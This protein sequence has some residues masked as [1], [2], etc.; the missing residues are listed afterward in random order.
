M[1]SL[2]NQRVQQMGLS[3]NQPDINMLEKKYVNINSKDRNVFMYPNSA[4]FEIDL[5]QSYSNIVSIKLDSC[6]LPSNTDLFS[7]RNNNL[8]FTFMFNNLYNP[9]E[10]SATPS[11]LSVMVYNVLSNYRNAYQTPEFIVLI[12]SGFY[13]PFQLCTEITNQ[14]NQLLTQY[15]YIQLLDYDDKYGTTFATQFYT[16]VNGIPVGGYTDFIVVYNVVEMNIWFGNQSSTFTLTQNIDLIN[17]FTASNLCNIY[18]QVNKTNISY[19]FAE[20][21]GL[22]ACPETSVIPTFAG[23]CRFTYG[24]VSSG[25]NGYWLTPN[26][27]NIGAKVSYIRCPKKINIL[28]QNYLYLDIS[29]LNCIDQTK[30]FVLDEGTI[31]TSNT[32]S[33]PQSCFAVIPIVSSPISQYYYSG[34]SPYKTFHPPKTRLQRLKIKVKFHN[35]LVIDFNNAEFSIMLEITILRP[36]M[37]SRNKS[38]NAYA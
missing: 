15:I 11:Q 5:P 2:N 4:E 37:V 6:S 38:F 34:T 3:E 28:G 35:G 26:T 30:P 13:D 14:M 12:R 27:Q 33:S 23:E 10:H 25:D 36:E 32:L 29:E 9:S 19:G 24:S 7:Y 16:E 22:S 8:I 18:K 31:T 17:K 20:Y 21:V 1:I